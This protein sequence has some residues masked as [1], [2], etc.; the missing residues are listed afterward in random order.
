VAAED[1]W[2]NI[3]NQ[4]QEKKVNNNTTPTKKKMS[5]DKSVDSVPKADSKAVSDLYR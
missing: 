4:E 1:W 5:K 3:V 2:K